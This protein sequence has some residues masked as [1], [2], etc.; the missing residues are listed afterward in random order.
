[1]FCGRRYT[2][3]GK[4]APGRPEME[5][6]LTP[7]MPVSSRGPARPLQP[8][9]PSACRPHSPKITEILE[10]SAFSPP[11]GW[12]PHGPLWRHREAT[13]LLDDAERYCAAEFSLLRIAPPS[14]G[15][16]LTFALFSISLHFNAD[17]TRHQVS[18]GGT[19][20]E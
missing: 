14:P 17:R 9:V 16:G 7:R 3:K 6:E 15:A 19:P 8:V 11:P 2:R 18:H 13:R 12:C 4:V 5:P 10:E 20:D 1:M